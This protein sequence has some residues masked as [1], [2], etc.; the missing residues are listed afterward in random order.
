MK[1]LFEP[2]QSFDPSCGLLWWLIYNPET[3]F[4]SFGERKLSKLGQLK[5]DKQVIEEL[6]SVKGEYKRPIDFSRKLDSLPTIKAMGGRMPFRFKLFEMGF[7]ENIYEWHTT[8]VVG[9]SAKGTYRQ[10][11]TIYPDKG[12]VA[13]RMIDPENYSGAED[14]FAEFEYMVYNLVK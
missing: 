14:D 12:I 11:L 7:Y 5:L 1:E 3:S 4:I 13:V 6:K 10:Y 8:K 9:I 2:G